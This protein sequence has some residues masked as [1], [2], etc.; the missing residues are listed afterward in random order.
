MAQMSVMDAKK[1]LERYIVSNGETN[2]PNSIQ[3][4]EDA[5]IVLN[6]LKI[7]NPAEAEKIESGLSLLKI[8][9]SIDYSKIKYRLELD[10]LSD[11]ENEVLTDFLKK[12][13]PKSAETYG[14]AVV[15][16]VFPTMRKPQDVD[17]QLHIK[18]GKLA[19][20][21]AQEACNTLNNL[22]FFNRSKFVVGL[23]DPG[24][25]LLPAQRNSVVKLKSTNTPIL[26]IHIEGEEGSIPQMVFGFK[27]LQPVLIE[28]MKCQ[29]VKQN[30]ID[31]F[32][33]IMTL[34]KG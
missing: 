7:I 18:D 23:H 12:N 1:A 34:R 22:S 26:D 28:G 6:A 11:R 30:Q 33:S 31:K 13:L 5:K 20:K 32:A 9:M 15:K 27:R 10:A 16:M 19:E 3:T 24:V 14:S 4:E 29:T 25:C 2:L 21:L 17:I 8:D